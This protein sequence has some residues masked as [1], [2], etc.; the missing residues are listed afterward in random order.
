MPGGAD[1]CP[2]LEVPIFLPSPW[3]VRRTTRTVRPS[4]SSSALADRASTSSLFQ[5]GGLEVAAVSLSTLERATD[6][7]VGMDGVD[8]DGVC[9]Q[10]EPVNVET[11][12]RPLL[13]GFR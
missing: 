9:L 10:F 12:A 6:E 7:S 13:P 3:R 2:H 11:A 5:V 4:P 8:G 1:A